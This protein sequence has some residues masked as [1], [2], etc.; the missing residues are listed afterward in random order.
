MMIESLHNALF[1]NIQVDSPTLTCAYN[2]IW[3][4]IVE[5]WSGSVVVVT[6]TSTVG[7]GYLQLVARCEC[8]F[9]PDKAAKSSASYSN[10]SHFLPGSYVIIS[11][12]PT[13]AAQG[14]KTCAIQGN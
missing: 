14:S 11:L 12:L 5:I 9:D 8:N 1:Y 13:H 4:K 3:S 10:A 6:A 7:E 2:S